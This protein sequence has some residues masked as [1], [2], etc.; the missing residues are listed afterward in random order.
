M[1][2][3]FNISKMSIEKTPEIIWKKPDT[4]EF[5][6]EILNDMPWIDE[7]K[8]SIYLNK[9]MRWYEKELAKL[10]PE[11]KQEL[12][13]G[14]RTLKQCFWL[15]YVKALFIHSPIK[16]WDEYMVLNEWKKLSMIAL[17][18]LIQE[19]KSLELGR[20]VESMKKDINLLSWLMNLETMATIAN[21]KQDI[22]NA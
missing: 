4:K 7:L 15:D 9:I 1:I 14:I 12:F 6:K 11:Q 16:I 18:T 22:S 20:S 8:V 13:D 10:T 19:A 17:F 3:K 5:G 21:T 2:F